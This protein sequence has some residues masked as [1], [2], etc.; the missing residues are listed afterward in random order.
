MKNWTRP[1]VSELEV[2]MTAAGLLPTSF[3]IVFGGGGGG[4]GGSGSDDG[5]ND[6]DGKD[7]NPDGTP[8]S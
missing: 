7:E 5:K 4:C 1:E 8:E 6:G 3:E 2:S